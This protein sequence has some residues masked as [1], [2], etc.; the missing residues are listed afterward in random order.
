MQRNLFILL[1]APTQTGPIKGALALAN[2][3]YEEFHITIVYLK[4]GSGQLPDTKVNVR[5]IILNQRGLFGIHKYFSYRKLLKNGALHNEP[6]SLS[7]CFSADFVN[8]FCG[9]FARTI[10]SIRGDL[11][12]NYHFDYGAPGL[13]LALFHLWMT[14]FFSDVISMSN[15]MAIQIKRYSCR[16]CVVIP[17]FVDEGSLEPYRALHRYRGAAFRFVFVGSLS[18]RKQPMLVLSAFNLLVKRGL[19]AHLDIV[20]DGHLKPALIALASKLRI[21]DRVKI[22]GW[23]PDPLPIVTAADTLVLPSLSEGQPRAALEAL[24]LGIPCILRSLEEHATLLSRP[25][26]GLFFTDDN[27]LV[28]KMEIMVKRGFAADRVRRCLLPTRHRVKYAVEKYMEL[29]SSK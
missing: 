7:M 10:C 5:Q 8:A 9:K 18:I 16:S 19:D 27:R 2:A 13:L 11:L 4:S 23:C 3:L 14:K 24:Y 6:I 25:G 28:E 22:W 17:N 12:K 20:G 1:P 15:C 21:N 29:L 26:S